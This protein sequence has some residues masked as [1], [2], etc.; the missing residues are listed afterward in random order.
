MTSPDLDRTHARLAV[1]KTKMAHG[2]ST[3]PEPHNIK[4]LSSS[5]QSIALPSES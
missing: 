5:E 1:H 2:A 4:A 3:T